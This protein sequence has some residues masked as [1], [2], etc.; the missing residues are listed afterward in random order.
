M[1]LYHFHQFREHHQK[2]IPK[3]KQQQQLFTNW[4]IHGALQRTGIAVIIICKCD[5][6]EA[7]IS[8]RKYSRNERGRAGH[9]SNG[10]FAFSRSTRVGSSEFELIRLEYDYGRKISGEREKSTLGL[11]FRKLNNFVLFLTCR[12]MQKLVKQKLF[13][14]KWKQRE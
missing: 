3:Q 13:P 9:H 5:D 4:N 14:Q 2:K 8:R 1:L 11:C 6:L 10:S 7:K 12:V